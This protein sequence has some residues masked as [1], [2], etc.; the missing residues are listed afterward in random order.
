MARQ[1]A[2]NLYDVSSTLTGPT[3]LINESGSDAMCPLPLISSLVAKLVR[4]RTVNAPST[5]SSPVQGATKHG[6]VAQ[7]GERLLC[8][9]DVAGSIPVTSTIFDVPA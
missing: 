3:K 4:Q 2:F 1:Q 9:Q 5:G 7:L 8:K 6:G